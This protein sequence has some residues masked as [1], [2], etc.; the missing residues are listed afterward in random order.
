MT[1]FDVFV[2]IVDSDHFTTEPLGEEDGARAPAS[3]NVE[4][5]SSGRQAQ[6]QPEVLG[7]LRAARM[8]GV[9]EEYPRGIVGIGG[10]AALLDGRG[11][12]FLRP[13]SRRLS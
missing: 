11:F 2:A 8:E 7:K 12:R 13:G 9:P 6:N 5:A 1:G 4:N 10:C 3:S